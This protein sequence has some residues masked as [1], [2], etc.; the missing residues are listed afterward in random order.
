MEIKIGCDPEVF[1][2]NE[3]SLQFACAHNLVPGTKEKPFPVPY[4]A[5]Q[6]DGMALE[7][8]IDPVTNADDFVR[9]VTRVYH[10]LG[11]MAHPY[12]LVPVPTANF[13]AQ[14]FED[15][16]AE[17]KIL[18]CEPDFN[19][20]TG[21]ANPRPQGDRP[22]RTA[23]GHVHIGWT[24]GVDPH[25]RGHFEDCKDVVKMLDCILGLQSLSYDKD[26]QRRSLYGKAGAFRPK[27]YGVEYRVLSNRWLTSEEL[28]R[29]VFEA[30]VKGVELVGAGIK[31]PL[32]STD[33]RY[34]IDTSI[35]HYA[36]KRKLKEFLEYHGV[37][38]PSA[39]AIKQAA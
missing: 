6:V 32:Y 22:F 27:S 1:I 8:N 31:P 14:V 26:K 19:A 16:P 34:I 36:Y 29:W 33:V 21:Q 7:F 13:N 9:N 18:G 38:Q 5:V 2:R 17:A 11:N 10:E 30:T 28:M 35:F 15:A 23:S 4:G 24:E 25:G 3:N 20:Y 12:K 37:P 39:E